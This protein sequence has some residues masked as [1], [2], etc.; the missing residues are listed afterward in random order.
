MWGL[1]VHDTVVCGSLLAFTVVGLCGY[2]MYLFMHN[3][4]NR[5]LH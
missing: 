1:V 3:A 2:Y 5:L 4:N